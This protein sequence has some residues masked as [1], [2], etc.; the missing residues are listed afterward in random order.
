MSEYHSQIKGQ[1]SNEFLENNNKNE[2]KCRKNNWSLEDEAM[3]NNQISIELNAFH[4]YNFLYSHF[5]NDSVGFPGLARFFKKS[6]DDELTLDE[7]FA[8]LASLM[9]I[10]IKFYPHTGRGDNFW[11]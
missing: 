2:S 8:E 1:V 3:I 6:S 4:I 5:S 9:I 11:R 10:S 7:L